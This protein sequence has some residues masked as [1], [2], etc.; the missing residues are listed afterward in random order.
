M[1]GPGIPSEREHVH[2]LRGQGLLEGISVSLP[3]SPTTSDQRQ[4]QVVPRPSALDFETPP[5]FESWLCHCV[6]LGKCLPS[7][8]YCLISK[9]EMTASGSDAASFWEAL[10]SRT[11]V[12]SSCICFHP[13][14]SLW[15]VGTPTARDRG[16]FSC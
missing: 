7:V 1:A 16:G 2:S 8:T 5:G 14:P 4:C 6:I 10:A 9:T 13:C 15:T 11:L 12:S 3:P